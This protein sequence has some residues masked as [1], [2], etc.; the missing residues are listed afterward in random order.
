VTAPRTL[1]LLLLA[2]LGAAGCEREPTAAVA[3]AAV[4]APRAAPS[5]AR[6]GN[7]VYPL[8]G[9]APER[10]LLT[11]KDGRFEPDPNLPDSER[12]V[13]VGELEALHAVGDLDDD[14]SPDAAVLL[15]WSGGGS[16][17]FY[18]LFAVLNEPGGLRA[19]DGLQLG[20]RID[21]RSIAVREGH[22]RLSYLGPGPNDAAC[23][24]TLRIDKA[25][26]IEAG[27]LIEVPVP[28]ASL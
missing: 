2:V 8:S 7:L 14:G 11:L 1:G 27:K 4:S 19:L 16:G 21:L 17:N 23:C 20:D 13:A 10:V 3:A 26:A 24:P 15:I 22:V 9:A 25:Y 12:L 28:A 5:F 6:L 18:E